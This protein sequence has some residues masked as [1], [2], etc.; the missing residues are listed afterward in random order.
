MKVAIYTTEAECYR[1]VHKFIE[2]GYEANGIYLAPTV[3]QYA[4][5]CGISFIIHEDHF[6]KWNSKSIKG[7]IDSV[8][9]A[10]DLNEFMMEEIF[11]IPTPDYSKYNHFTDSPSTEK[12]I[13][14]LGKCISRKYFCKEFSDVYDVIADG[15]WTPKNKSK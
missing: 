5:G 15:V 14:K 13:R 1:D 11:E 10:Q 3:K 9:D 12:N 4:E 2:A 8:D 6:S 7:L